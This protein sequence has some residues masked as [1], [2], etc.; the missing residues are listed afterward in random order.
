[1]ATTNR[2]VRRPPG[3][4]RQLRRAAGILTILGATIVAAVGSGVSPAGALTGSI[5]T[6]TIADCNVVNANIYADKSDVYLNGGPT[7]G[8]GGPGLPDGNYYVQVTEPNGTLLGTSVGTAT[9]TPVT[10]VGGVFASCYQLETL[11]ENGGLPG[12]ADTTN[13]GH[14]YKVWVSMD[15]TFPNP[16]SATDNFKALP[17]TDIRVVPVDPTVVVNIACGVEDTYTIPDV[18]GV[19]YQVNGVDT[20]PGTYNLP[21]GFQIDITATA[22]P[23]FTI[24]ANPGPWGPYIGSAVP[25]CPGGGGGGGGGFQPADVPEEVTPRSPRQ[26]TSTECEVEDTYRILATEGVVYS[27]DGVVTDAGDYPLPTGTTVVVAAAAADGFAFPDGT[28]TTWT[29]TGN[30]VEVCPAPPV[31]EPA[32]VEPEPE[33]EPEVVAESAGAPAEVT[34]E[35]PRTGSTLFGLVVVGSGLLALG[36][37]LTFGSRREPLS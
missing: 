24:G 35:L 28:T 27:V 34:G 25:V 8:G 4:A 12:F 21:D 14:E 6:T 33:P 15:P 13:N 29:F 22:D 37:L 30:E 17:D 10:V 18:P 31:A 9:P 26:R 19:T 32:V 3:V 36:A 11:V 7:G 23:G 1:M 2:P 5:F 20:A 16:D